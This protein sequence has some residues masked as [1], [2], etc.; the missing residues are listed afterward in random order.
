MKLLPNRCFPDRIAFVVCGALLLALF[1]IGFYLWWRDWAWG[2]QP[3]QAARTHRSRGQPDP[4]VRPTRRQVLAEARTHFTYRGRPIHPAIVA[5]FC[6]LLADGDSPVLALD[7]SLAMVED[8][9]SEPVEDSGH[10]FYETVTDRETDPDEP[11]PE[12]LWDHFGYRR[13]GELN[14]GTVVLDTVDWSGGGTGRFMTLIFV[15]VEVTSVGDRDALVMKYVDSFPLGDRSL[16]EVRLEGDH[17]NIEMQP[18]NE[19]TGPPVSTN[20]VPS[21]QSWRRLIR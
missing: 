6:P 4:A 18:H 1:D 20:Y 17:V 12:R 2:N 7:V 21:P 19:F 10:G 13:L 14:D 3:F 15:R 16:G 9:F 5:K 11:F 8:A